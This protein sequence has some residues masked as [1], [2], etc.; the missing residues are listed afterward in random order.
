MLSKS[1]KGLSIPFPSFTQTW[2]PQQIHSIIVENT[3]KSL[4]AVVRGWPYIGWIASVLL[5]Q[6]WNSMS[7]IPK[8][9]AGIPILVLSGT[10]DVVVPP[11]H[12]DEIWQLVQAR[13]SSISQSPSDQVTSETSAESNKSLDMFQKVEWGDHGEIILLIWVCELTFFSADTWTKQ[14][15][16]AAVK[17]F[18]QN[19]LAPDVI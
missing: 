9:P 15:H 8:I 18:L 1:L 14:Q 10:H 6:K 19:V 11:K 2:S 16:N 3:F 12:S 4:P 17:E 5:S 13:H 7:R